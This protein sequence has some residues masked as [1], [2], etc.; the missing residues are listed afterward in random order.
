LF[1][2]AIIFA[3]DET[4]TITTYYPSPYGSY[5]NLTVANRLGVGTASPN[6]K[7]SVFGAIQNA[8]AA[9]AS[10]FTMARIWVYGGTGMDLLNYAYL[11]Y[12]NDANMRIVYS[13]TSQGHNLI[14][15][16][17]SATDNTG[18]FTSTMTLTSA[19]NLAIVGA[20]SKGSGSFLIDHPLDPANKVLRHSF[21]ESPDMKNIYDGVAILNETGECLINL[22]D[23]FQALNKDFRYQLA[24]IGKPA[25]LYIKEEIKDNKFLIGG[26][27]PGM[28]ICWQV[29][30]IRKDAYARKHPIVV[31]EEK[32]K[33]GLPKKGE[34]LHP[35]AFKR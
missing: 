28:K 11:G 33:Q 24:A 9:D 17:S 29:T 7:L 20:L 15:G 12:G 13:N 31:E 26:G 30:G 23:Y 6:Y 25:M 16:T 21:T 10:P 19:G 3:A 18:T 4:L 5:N 32:G 8:A 14:F 1:C 2:P 34:Y 27:K 22:P 35:D